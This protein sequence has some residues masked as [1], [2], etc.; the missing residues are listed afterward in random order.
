MEPFVLT[1]FTMDSVTGWRLKM[2]LQALDEC[3]IIIIIIFYFCSTYLCIYWF[4]HIFIDLS[5]IIFFTISLFISTDWY[6]YAFVLVFQI[7]NH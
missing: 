7:R 5:Y 3:V 1:L 6:L 4:S 2:K